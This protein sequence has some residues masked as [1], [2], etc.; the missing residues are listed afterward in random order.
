MRT[1]ARS[2]GIGG[3]KGTAVRTV[4]PTGVFDVAVDRPDRPDRS[5]AAVLIAQVDDAVHIA[6]HRGRALLDVRARARREIAIPQAHLTGRAHTLALDR[7]LLACRSAVSGC[8]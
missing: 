6:L 8:W 4:A 2:D 5:S 7:P 3:G 1:S